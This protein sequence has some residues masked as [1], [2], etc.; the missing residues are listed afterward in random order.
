MK[1]P[2]ITFLPRATIALIAAL[3]LA[4]PALAR[5]PARGS[6][7]GPG[8]PEMQ[9]ARK[10]LAAATV[11]AKLQLS[12]EQKSALQKILGQ[13]RQIRD[14]HQSDSAVKQHKAKA[15]ALLAKATAEVR[16]NQGEMSPDTR[17]Q[18]EAL[19]SERAP[20]R[21]EMRTT[22]R[23]LMQ[24]ARNVLTPEQQQRL[25]QARGPMGRGPG[26]GGGRGPGPHAGR[27]PSGAPGFWP[28]AGAGPCA[29]NPEACEGRGRGMGAGGAPDPG[30]RGPRGKQR[31]KK[32]MHLL[33]S[34]EFI[35]ELGR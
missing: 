30:A 17:A 12:R 29:E 11:V 1:R 14:E 13:A 6:Q 21:Q 28:G 3:S 32:M 33:L 15:K 34:D 31:G 2:L 10:Q 18:L 5:G 27:G 26:A 16:A 23:E 19:R 20:E 7:Q 22:M 24:S 8:D 9:A 25:Q 4:A 35:A